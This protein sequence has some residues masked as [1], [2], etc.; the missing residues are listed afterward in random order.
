LKFE[1]G[2]FELD[3]E[4]LEF[5]FGIFEFEFERFEF[6]FGRFEFEI[7]EIE[8]E[9]FEFE[10]WVFPRRRRLYRDPLSFD[11]RESFAD[12]PFRARMPS[13]RLSLCS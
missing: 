12:S 11:G 4:R 6:E 7:F 13:C 8:V 3:F 1:F 9:R 5:E 2:I 10:K